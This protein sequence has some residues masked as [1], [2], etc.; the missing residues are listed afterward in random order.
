[1][2]TEIR[3]PR[4]QIDL[5]MDMQIDGSPRVFDRFRLT[6]DSFLVEQIDPSV[7]QIMV[8]MLLIPGVSSSSRLARSISCR[9]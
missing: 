7:D 3:F 2:P 5:Q 6:A 8:L 4:E 1:M 9:R